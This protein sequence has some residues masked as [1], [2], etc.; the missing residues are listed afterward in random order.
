MTLWCPGQTSQIKIYHFHT[1]VRNNDLK[2]GWLKITQT[3][4][5]DQA[6]D[7][8]SQHFFPFSSCTHQNIWVKVSRVF[9]IK[10]GSFFSYLHHSVASSFA[11]AN[12]SATSSPPQSTMTTSLFGLSLPSVGFFSTARTTSIPFT[13]FPNTTC[14]PSSH[15]VFFTVMKN[16]EPLVSLPALAIDSHPA[17]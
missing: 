10:Q 4:D 16:W 11:T 12:G 6:S 7:I 9:T 2:W 17:P 3:N 14:L 13:I 8:T 5:G 15:E 1:I